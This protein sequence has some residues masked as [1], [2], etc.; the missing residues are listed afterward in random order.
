VASTE[1][2][3]RARTNSKS[4]SNLPEAGFDESDRAR[5]AVTIEAVYNDNSLEVLRRR[6]SG[7]ADDWEIHKDQNGSLFV[8]SKQPNVPS[9]YVS[10]LFASGDG[11]LDDAELCKA[12]SSGDSDDDSGTEAAVKEHEHMMSRMRAMEDQMKQLIEETHR[13]ISRGDKIH[14][15]GRPGP[16]EDWARELPDLA[17]ELPHPVRTKSRRSQTKSG[18]CTPSS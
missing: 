18:R 9:A 12:E 7:G 15:N 2:A 6:T 14:D 16:S 5:P 8:G 11:V 13:G 4:G 1:T 3:G 10:E 17:W